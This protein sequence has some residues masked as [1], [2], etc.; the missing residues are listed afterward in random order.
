MTF[1]S[2][3]PPSSGTGVRYYQGD[4][5]PTTPQRQ[6]EGCSTAWLH[7]KGRNRHHLEYW[8]DY[9]PAGTGTMIGN[10]CRCGMWPRCSATG[11]PPAGP[12]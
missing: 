12:I 5:A 10:G 3:R 2:T 7:H 4:R 9:D 6:A 8:I 1:Q 11:L